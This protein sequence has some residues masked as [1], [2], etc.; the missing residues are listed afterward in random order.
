MHP[1][2]A[3]LVVVGVYLFFMRTRTNAPPATAHGSN[4][5]TTY[6]NV[7]AG[8]VGGLTGYMPHG[9][10]QQG[11]IIYG[12]TSPTPRDYVNAGNTSDVPAVPLSAFHGPASSPPVPGVKVI[13]YIGGTYDPA[14]LSQSDWYYYTEN[15]T[16]FPAIGQLLFGTN[17]GS[18]AYNQGVN[19]ATY[20]VKPAAQPHPGF[21]AAVYNAVRTVASQ[22]GDPYASTGQPLAY[23]S[24]VP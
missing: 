6:P 12:H 17:W 10:D 20:N 22:Q 23:G 11:S 19:T 18:D 24:I 1:A 15:S 16:V 3:A 13:P 7:G 21:A 8:Q 4:L 2:I 5:L 14:K 9:T